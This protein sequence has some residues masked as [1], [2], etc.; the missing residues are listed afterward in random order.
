MARNGVP[1]A[2]TIQEVEEESANDPELSVVRTCILTD[3]QWDLGDVSFR[4]V[5]L[6]L[7]VLG[8]LVIRGEPRNSKDQTTFEKQGL[9]AKY[10][11]TTG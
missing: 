4:S 10:C 8:K 5:R 1:G 11:N 6:E 7:S 9:V 3:S 2:I